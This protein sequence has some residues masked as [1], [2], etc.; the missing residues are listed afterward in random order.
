[1][2]LG[3]SGFD[4]DRFTPEL[5]AL[6]GDGSSLMSEAVTTTCEKIE[7]VHLL[8]A[9][10]R[11]PGTAL[12]ARLLDRLHC[13]PDGLCSALY[14]RGLDPEHPIGMPVEFGLACI[15]EPSGQMLQALEHSIEE[16]GLQQVSEEL[17][18]LTL[19][20]YVGEP[21]VRVLSATAQPEEFARFREELERAAKL[22]AAGEQRPRS[23]FDPETGGVVEALF[24][25]SGRRALQHLREE[26]LGTGASKATG[27][28]LLYAL[29]GIEDGVLQGA[30][31]AQAI[32][33][34]AGVY[35][36]LGRLL[37]K[38]RA[39]RDDNFE[40]TRYSLHESV[41]RILDAAATEAARQ[42]LPISELHVARALMSRAP[43]LI[44][45]FLAGRQ[46]RVG[47]LREYIDTAEAHVEEQAAHLRLSMAQIEAELRHRILGQEHALARVIPWVKRLRFGFPR[48]RGPAAVFLFLG[49]S[50]TGKTQLA[51]ELARTVYG[52]EDDLVMLEMGQFGTRES[53]NIFI[54][55]P[56]GYVGYGEGKLTNG[57]RDKP[58]SVVLF[59]EIEKA[60]EDVWMALMRFLDEGLI[61]DPAGPTRDGRQCIV[62][63]TSN[64]GADVLAQLL[65]PDTDQIPYQAQAELEQAIRDT[66]LPYLKR[67]EIYNRVDDK[68]VFRPFSP[69]TYQDL[70]A[71]Q[72]ADELNKFLHLHNT[73]VDVLPD[74]LA[75]LAQRAFEAKQEG[76]RCVP[77]LIN[78]YIIVPVIDVISCD[79]DRHIP[80]VFVSKRA[81]DQG[82]IAEEA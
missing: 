29:V 73:R 31:Q 7:P 46:V 55:A 5:A 28:H 9:M 24:D 32:D 23:A 38:P 80:R 48:D 33:P 50:G 6:I 77:R 75:W 16:L 2:L 68:V 53:I 25:G 63:L 41:V 21:V 66:V 11:T 17:F 18:L 56:P 42:A 19:L 27:L 81:D 1:M 12:R 10:V 52:S 45:D 65:P 62:V 61:G 70:L 20:R 22:E 44:D 13:D 51:K 67:P 40:L 49:P 3:P 72:V 47:E 57:L 36:P 30:L 78:Q 14:R 58:R 82:T 15:S 37:S 69:E 8:A 26:T 54:G 4:T 76:A 64:L 34:S 79:E 74:V 35:R 43:G 71:A 60:H 59:D 39:K